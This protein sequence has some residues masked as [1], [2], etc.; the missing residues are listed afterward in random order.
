M[1]TRIDKLVYKAVAP[2]VLLCWFIFVSFDALVGLAGEFDEIGIGEYDVLRVL[3]YIALSLPR[4]LYAMFSTAAVVGSMLGLGALAARSEL[5]ALQAAGASK[6]RIGLSTVWAVGSLLLVALVL[7]EWVGPK[8]DRMAADLAAQSKAQGIAFSGSGL[9]LRDGK[10]VWNAKRIVITGPGQIDLWD[11]WRYEFG[12]DARLQQVVRSERASFRDN[13]FELKNGSRDVLADAEV[14][15]EKFVTLELPTFL[16]TGLIE[17]HTVRPN[18]QAT[19][20]LYETVRYAK[21]NKL[22]ALKFESAFWYRIF[23]PLIA[24][25]LAFVAT[26]FAFANVRS[27][28]LGQR[29]LLGISLGVGFFFTHRTLINFAETERSGLVLVNIGPP[30]VLVALTIWALR[31]PAK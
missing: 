21:V 23:Y 8:G 16:D 19:Y 28:G 17:S 13:V 15:S 22:D 14:K 10:A 11:I 31:R 20:D 2:A 29:L 27:G 9:W 18:Q 1:F 7:G 3:E 24:L 6:L 5:I 30:L 26:P 25:S 12:Q 4:R